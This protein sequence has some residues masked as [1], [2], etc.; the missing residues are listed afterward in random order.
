MFTSETVLVLSREE[1][2]MLIVGK[3]RDSRSFA[4]GHSNEIDW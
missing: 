2:Y 1:I 4:A 3:I